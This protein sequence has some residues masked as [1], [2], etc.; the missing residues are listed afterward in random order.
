LIGTCRILR[1]GGAVTSHFFSSFLSWASAV[2]DRSRKE[3]AARRFS[4]GQLR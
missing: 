1:P 3:R 2:V 4:M